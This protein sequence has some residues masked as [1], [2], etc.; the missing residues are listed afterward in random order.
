LTALHRFTGP[1]G[2]AP[3][4]GLTLGTDGNFYGTTITGGTYALGTIFR[5]TPAGTVTTLYSFKGETDS[6]A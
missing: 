6:A 4:G 1:D 3:A 5:M 2:Q